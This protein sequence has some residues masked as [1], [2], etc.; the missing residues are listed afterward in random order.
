MIGYNFNL[1]LIFSYYV[2]FT[3]VVIGKIKTAYLYIC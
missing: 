1:Y 2:W 3:H